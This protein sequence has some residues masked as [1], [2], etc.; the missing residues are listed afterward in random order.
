MY[1]L[2]GRV[3]AVTGGARGIGRA[4]CLRLASEGADIAVVDL[5]EAGAQVVV[6]EV[7]ALGRQAVAL[8]V[9]VTNPDQVNRMV[10][11][12][13]ATLGSLDIMVNNA[14]IQ[15][16]A[17]LL[18]TEEQQWD[19]MFD[20]NLKSMWLCARA[21]AAQMIR[22]GRGG[23]I[24]NASSRAGK[25]ASSLP[26]GAYVVSKHAVVGLTRQLALELAPHG[27]L[28]NAYCPGVVDTPM[29]DLIDR[30][31]AER[32]GVPLGSVKKGAVDAI[33]L[34]R[35]EQPEDVAR[36]VAFLASSESD[37]MTG[38]AINITGGSVMH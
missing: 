20:V 7:N 38:Q 27:V 32:R 19:R 22:Q 17:T 5:D 33:P 8:K 15:Y 23:R 2:D 28:V 6:G 24:I 29:W 16:I 14:G 30:L 10:A 25:V 9:D 4:I 36:L 21:A 35:I 11:E 3:A 13:V 12:T 31:V 1:N 18:E 34:G 37:Y 26:I